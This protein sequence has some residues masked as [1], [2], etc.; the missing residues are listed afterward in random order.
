LDRGIEETIRSLDKIVFSPEELSHWM[1]STEVT[2]R[3]MYDDKD[4]EKIIFQHSPD[5]KVTR[6]FV[7]N[8]MQEIA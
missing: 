1:T 7:K 3:H 2:A 8:L 5:E 4:G 6:F